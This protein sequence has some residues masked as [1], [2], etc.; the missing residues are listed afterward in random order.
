MR[1]ESTRLNGYY[2]VE[3]EVTEYTLDA[4]LLDCSMGC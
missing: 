4:L 3:P 1:A 2:H